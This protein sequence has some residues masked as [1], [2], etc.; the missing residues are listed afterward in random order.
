MLHCSDTYAWCNSLQL[1]QNDNKWSIDIP[2]FFS[3]NIRYVHVREES[4]L[5]S[6]P[7]VFMS[8]R[9]KIEFPDL[10]ESSQ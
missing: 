3:V 10:V 7:S 1:N 5:F 8:Q 4:I 9:A 2:D 6:L